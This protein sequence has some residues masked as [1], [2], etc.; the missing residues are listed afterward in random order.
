MINHIPQG[1]YGTSA[2]WDSFPNI[3][4]LKVS[5]IKYG[6]SFL[7]KKVRESDTEGTIGKK[8][9]TYGHYQLSLSL[10]DDMEWYREN[11]KGK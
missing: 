3:V 5:F 4:L 6:L 8:N 2:L 9:M 7:E 10:I 1:F 11:E